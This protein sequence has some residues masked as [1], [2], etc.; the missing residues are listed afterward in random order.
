VV[1]VPPHPGA[2][3]QEFEYPFAEARRALAALGDFADDVAAVVSLHSDALSAVRVNFSGS[4]REGFEAGFAE[5]V[6]AA[7]QLRTSLL[8]DRDLL[9]AE[10]AEA[11]RLRDAS[12]DAIADWESDLQRHE[13]GLAEQRRSE[14]MAGGAR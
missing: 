14:T 5:V 1:T 8:A 13:D 3:P 2:R 9:E 6:G 4:A 7:E 12:L 11:R 10:I